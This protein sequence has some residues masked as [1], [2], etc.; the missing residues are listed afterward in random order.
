[1]QDPALILYESCKS[2]QDKR[3]KISMKKNI[4]LNLKPVIEQ[5]IN[6]MILLH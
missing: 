3:L 1:M 4:S 5:K 6:E 2:L